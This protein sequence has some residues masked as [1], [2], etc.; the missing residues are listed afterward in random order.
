MCSLFTSHVNICISHKSQYFKNDVRY[1][2]AIINAFKWLQ[3]NFRFV[4]T[5]KEYTPVKIQ[6]HFDKAYSHVTF[7]RSIHLVKKISLVEVGKYI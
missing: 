7:R 5:L 6:V 2:R 4:G 3:F 1:K